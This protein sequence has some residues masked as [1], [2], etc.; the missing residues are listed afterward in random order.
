MILNLQN[1]KSQVTGEVL[2]RC[3]RT[4][5]DINYVKLQAETVGLTNFGMV[6]TMNVLY[7]IIKPDLDEVQLKKYKNK[8]M[9]F[10]GIVNWETIVNVVEGEAQG[11]FRFNP[12]LIGARKLCN[13]IWDMDLRVRK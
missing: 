1:K 6:P 8:K 2:I 5:K 12:I 11:S 3:F 9:P 7:K 10:K 4:D 13:E